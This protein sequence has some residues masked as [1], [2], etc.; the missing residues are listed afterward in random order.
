MLSAC[1]RLQGKKCKCQVKTKCSCDCLRG[2]CHTP[3]KSF[4]SSFFQLSESHIRGEPQMNLQSSFS[5]HFTPSWYKRALGLF[6]PFHKTGRQRE[7]GDETKDSMWWKKSGEDLWAPQNTLG[8]YL[9]M[10]MGGEEKPH[11]VHW[12]V[13]D[14]IIMSQINNRAPPVL[15]SVILLAQLQGCVV[16]AD[17]KMQVQQFD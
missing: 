16:C 12:S 2:I 6:G 9:L 8:K 4:S 5:F 7:A 15:G 1:G 14:E 3:S 11:A 13:K 17:L 10:L